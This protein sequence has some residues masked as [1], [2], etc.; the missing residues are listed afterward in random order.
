M[1]TSEAL[2]V[3]VEVHAFVSGTLSVDRFEGVAEA[4][5]T[6]AHL[7]LRFVGENLMTL[8]VPNGKHASTDEFVEF[9]ISA[10]FPLQSVE[11]DREEE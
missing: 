8:R 3:H 6:L 11:P 5:L 1:T 10:G 4:V 9:F 7:G 2:E